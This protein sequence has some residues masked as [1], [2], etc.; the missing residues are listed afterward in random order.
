MKY[1]NQGHNDIVPEYTRQ[2]HL[3][4]EEELKEIVKRPISE[5]SMLR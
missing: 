4:Q 5:A 1:S 2:T 3:N